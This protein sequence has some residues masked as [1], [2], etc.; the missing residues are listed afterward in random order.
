VNCPFGR[1]RKYKL[2]EGVV[3]PREQVKGNLVLR[4]TGLH[5]VDAI[6]LLVGIQMVQDMDQHVSETVAEPCYCTVQ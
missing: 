5:T 1:A 6:V 4:Y 2:P 3:Q